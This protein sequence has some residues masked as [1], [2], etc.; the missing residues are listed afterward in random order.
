MTVGSAGKQSFV[1]GGDKYGCGEECQRSGILGNG[2]SHLYCFGQ[3]GGYNLYCSMEE[4]ERDEFWREILIP[5][6]ELALP[7]RRRVG[8]GPSREDSRFHLGREPSFIFLRALREAFVARHAWSTATTCALR[9]GQKSTAWPRG[10]SP[11]E[12]TFGPCENHFDL[13]GVDSVFWSAG[14][15]LVFEGEDGHFASFWKTDF[16]EDELRGDTVAGRKGSIYKLMGTESLASAQMR[17]S[18][19]CSYTPA[20]KSLRASVIRAHGTALD[21][22]DVESFQFYSTMIYFFKGARGGKVACDPTSPSWRERASSLLWVKA[23][24]LQDTEGHEE[25][26]PLEAFISLVESLPSD[27]DATLR[28]EPTLFVR[29]KPASDGSAKRAALK[30]AMEGCWH[31]LADHYGD[32]AS[33]PE[34]STGVHGTCFFSSAT[35]RLSCIAKLYRE[36]TSELR[37]KAKV[38]KRRP[39]PS[40]LLVNPLLNQE[41]KA[42]LAELEVLDFA[43]YSPYVWLTGKTW[44]VVPKVAE[45][46]MVA[47]SCRE[48]D[49]PAFPDALFV[50]GGLREKMARQVIPTKPTDSSLAKPSRWL[51]DDSSLTRLPQ[52]WFHSRRSPTTSRFDKQVSLFLEFVSVAEDP[53]VS[54]KRVVVS[55]CLLFAFCCLTKAKSWAVPAVDEVSLDSSSDSISSSG[56]SQERPPEKKAVSLARVKTELSRR[57]GP[58]FVTPEG[59]TKSIKLW[60]L[61]TLLFDNPKVFDKSYRRNKS[62]MWVEALL[63]MRYAV[64]S[65]P[66]SSD[67]NRLKEPGNFLSLV[68]LCWK[69]TLGFTSFWKCTEGSFAKSGGCCMSLDFEDGCPSSLDPAADSLEGNVA[70]LARVQLDDL[71]GEVKSKLL[72]LFK[73]TVSD[74]YSSEDKS[75]VRLVAVCCRCSDSYC[76]SEVASRAKAVTFAVACFLRLITVIPS[77]PQS[78]LAML[79][80]VTKSFDKSVQHHKIKVQYLA[81]YSPFFHPLPEGKKKAKLVLLPWDKVLSAIEDLY[82]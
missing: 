74:R 2:R 61:L 57:S 77:F 4:G 7:D 26:D 76:T 18:P 6:V 82:E 58:L 79:K 37:V 41:G 65:C 11:F 69:E 63:K 22:F 8:T 39:M 75:F 25:S 45:K 44:K 40:F 9:L 60:T 30:A 13:G 72:S 5:A 14:C 28:L 52:A 19:P 53:R 10:K 56:E 23:S 33:D 80:E 73:G 48:N 59:V 81:S 47:S 49:F 20:W 3:L 1:L 64:S 50:P 35:S 43:E 46:L 55:F 42:N 16:L 68:S 70:R 31:S 17:G 29:F 62:D 32:L 27:T 78:A 66:P 15:N 36:A 54:A 38:R 71:N 67:L 12:T 51:P 34:S 21:C 24:C